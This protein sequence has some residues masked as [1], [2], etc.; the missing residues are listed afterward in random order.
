MSRIRLEGTEGNT[1]NVTADLMTIGDATKSGP[2]TNISCYDCEAISPYTDYPA[3]RITSADLAS[4][5]SSITW[6]GLI[7]QGGGGGAGLRIDTG[8]SL[9]FRFQQL[10]AA[11]TMLTV[12]PSTSVGGPIY[13]DGG[14]Q[15]V[16]W[17]YNVDSTS[18]QKVRWPGGRWGTPQWQSGNTGVS[19]QA[20]DGTVNGGNARGLNSV[21]LQQ[22]RFANIHAASG[23]NSV[24]AGGS[25]NA[26]ANDDATVSGGNTNT[27]SGYRSTI[28]GGYGNVTIGQYAFACGFYAAA[29]SHGQA[30][31]ASGRFAANGDAQ[32]STYLLRGSTSTATAVRL[33]GDQAAASSGAGNCVVINANFRYG[34]RITLTAQDTTNPANGYTAVWNGAHDLSR[35]STAASTVFDGGTAT[36]A[37]DAT[38]SSGS[39]T[40]IGATASADTTNACLNVTFTPPSGNSAAWHAVA[41]VDTT[42][43]Q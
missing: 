30:V 21:D 3:L 15:E 13:L 4:S 23:K 40:G 32:A 41:R 20:A 28:C 24:I 5:P 27:A 9:Y 1:N 42:E 37:P 11:Q 34:V 29:R 17:T 38:R 35:G 16:N 12:G 14:G 2:I 31:F 25:G 18:L 22:N 7:G 6:T 33:T 19:A 36:V 39:V 8:K 10:S 43:I 26:A